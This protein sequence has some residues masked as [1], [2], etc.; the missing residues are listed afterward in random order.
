[1]ETAKSISRKQE[2]FALIED[3]QSSRLTKTQFCKEREISRSRFYYWQR[4]YRQ[5]QEEDTGFLPVQI[6][7]RSGAG[8]IEIIYPSGVQVRL[9]GGVPLSF[10]RSLITSA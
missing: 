6:S 9:G 4:R 7:G 8:D 3:S 5:Q 10:V 2:M 1:M